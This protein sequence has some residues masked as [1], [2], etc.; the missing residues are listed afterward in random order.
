[1]FPDGRWIDY[2]N[3]EIRGLPANDPSYEK[4]TVVWLMH[5]MELS[6]QFAHMPVQIQNLGVITEKPNIFSQRHRSIKFSLKQLRTPLVTH[7]IT[8]L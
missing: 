8:S 3:G 5:Q 6:H 7:I 1:M 2:V 4:L